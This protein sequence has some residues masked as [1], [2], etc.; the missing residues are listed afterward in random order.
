MI[1][2]L[3]AGYSL[4]L[5]AIGL[6]AREVVRARDRAALLDA[7]LRG[8]VTLLKLRA[9]GGTLLDQVDRCPRCRLALPPGDT[10]PCGW[11]R[12]F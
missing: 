11:A 4:A 9:A 8:A 1:E 3:F 7:R 2:T 6:S 5:L 12:P 10:C